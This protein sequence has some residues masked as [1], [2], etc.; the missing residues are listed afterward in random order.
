MQRILIKPLQ[1][2]PYV[3]P[4]AMNDMKSHHML[5]VK[6]LINNIVTFNSVLNLRIS[7]CL[8]CLYRVVW[9]HAGSLKSRKDA[10][11]LP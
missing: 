1:L 2:D 11:E 10:Q 3:H 6:G 5:Q 7:S 9:M 4:D 8:V